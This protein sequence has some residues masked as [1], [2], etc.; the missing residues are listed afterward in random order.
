MWNMRH[1]KAALEC[2]TGLEVTLEFA[3]GFPL[4]ITLPVVPFRFG[5]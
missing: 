4:K 5:W 2:G 1:R 3:L